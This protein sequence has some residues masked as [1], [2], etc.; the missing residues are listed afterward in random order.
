MPLGS[1]CTVGTPGPHTPQGPR[2]DT[3][4]APAQPLP[5]RSWVWGP[6]VGWSGRSLPGFRTGL[7]EVPRGPRE[8]RV[9]RLPAPLHCPAPPGTSACSWWTPWQP[10]AGSP[11]TWTSKV[12]P[13]PVTPAT[14]AL[15]GKAPSA[16]PASP[17]S[18]H[19]A[20]RA[21]RDP[22]ANRHPA[23][24]GAV[25]PRCGR[26]AGGRSSSST[27]RGAGP[28]EWAGD[29][30]GWATVSPSAGHMP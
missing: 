25:S 19:R 6:G 14:A 9:R 8:P 29:V 27:W 7:L 13:G 12:R 23:S 10:W 3:C 30:P 17:P 2:V 11:S 22:P 16:A 4:S 5:T 26:Q 15:E 20:L 21:G 24:V 1:A 28:Q 18:A